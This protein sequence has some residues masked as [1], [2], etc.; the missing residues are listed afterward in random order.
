MNEQRD[1]QASAQ[2][3]YL[4]TP[5]YY[6]N[7]RPHLGTCYTTVVADIIAR[8]HRMNGRDVLLVT[9]SDENSQ[10]TVIAAKEAGLE[11]LPYC[12]EMVKHY[13]EA[14]RMLNIGPYEFVRTTEPRH[15]RL[16]QHFFSRLY[17]QGDIYK[18]TYSGWYCTPCETFYT[19]RELTPE[20]LCPKCERPAHAVDEEAYFFR[21]SAYEERVKQYFADRPD[22]VQP[23][24]RRNEMASRLN[25]GLQDNCISRSSLE[26]GI[27]LPWDE[28]H[29]FYVWVEALLTYLTGSGYRFDDPESPHYWPAQLNLMAKDIPWF[30][31]IVFP[32][33]LMAYGLPPV[34]QM[35]VHGYWLIR[36]GKMSKS[37]GGTITPEEA[38]GCVGADGLRYFYAREVPLGLDGSISLDA[39]VERYNF[40]LGN[41]LGNL[42]NRLLP[43]TERYFEGTVPARGEFAEGDEELARLTQEVTQRALHLYAD[44]ELSRVLEEV[45]SLVRAANKY[46]DEHK[47]WEL[48]QEPAR[49][50]E[51]SAGFN[52][53]FTLLRNIAVLLAPVIPGSAQR[54]WEQL[55]LPGE[56]QA[57]G[58]SALDQ[59]FPAG[60][61]IGKPEP[62][63]PRVEMPAET[64]AQ[65]EPAGAEPVPPA[66][67]ED[68]PHLK[69]EPMV[70]SQIS[71]DEFMRVEIIA[72]KITSA[73]RVEGTD[74]LIKM[75]VDDGRGG[76]VCVAGIGHVYEP[77]KLV[78]LTLPMVA[79]LKPAKL[80]G[81][82]S[83]GMILA[84]QDEAGDLSLV[85]LDKDIAPGT[86]VI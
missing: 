37:K 26:W 24:F 50:D 62:L 49:K 78:G 66:H 9:G 72:A 51:F 16:V 68:E 79:N 59:P 8:Y 11:P 18:G 76:R 63:F 10:K 43:M 86:K 12:D 44:Y 27:R 35:I 25:E 30:H 48:A 45:F 33:M 58:F 75:N 14:W 52:L 40:E 80:R 39:I 81:V 7:A 61:H 70:A 77:E 71:F 85:V 3:F 82:L 21:L 42:L 6:I 23:D 5:I 69:E 20:S 34:E 1:S 32:A 54:I 57:E 31:A 55:G 64:P 13:H 46:I 17:E 65:A 73:E 60:T 36:G 19:E 2:R 83:E 38:I 28:R 67:T 53:L 47:P 15:V 4:T 29:V 22:F 84:A 56:V 74:K 41:D